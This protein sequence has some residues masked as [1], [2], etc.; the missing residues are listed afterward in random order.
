MRKCAGIFIFA[1][2]VRLVFITVWYETGNGDRISADS[3]GYLPI[4]QSIV[5]WK[6]F[7]FEGKPFTR[8][9]PLYCLF[10]GILSKLTPFPLGIYIAQALIGAFSCVLLYVMGRKMFD[11]ISGF[12]AACFFSVDYATLRFTVEVMPE[13]IFVLWLLLGFY[14]FISFTKSAGKTDLVLSSLF[15]GL[16]ALTKDGI[17][18]FVPVMAL[19]F[20][21]G[22]RPFKI[23]VLTA[24][25]F[26]MLFVLTI[27]PWALRNTLL[28]GHFSLVT[29]S[30]GH[31]FY[32][33]NNPTTVGN[34]TGGEWRY[35][36]DYNYP[37]DDPNL[38][39]LYTW[40]A[41]RYLSQSALE[42]IRGNPG[43]FFQLMKVKIVNM[44]RPYQS[45]SPKLAKWAMALTYIP[46][47]FLGLA[48]LIRNIGRWKE[49]LPVYGLICY[50]FLIH[51]VLF[52]QI[53]FRYPVMP[54]FM[55]FAASGITAIKKNPGCARVQSD[56]PGRT[57]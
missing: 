39:P 24:V 29:T 4:G 16:A 46:V 26:L 48:G 57:Q 14:Y 35:E 7:Q 56:F 51:I 2:L 40:E 20:L 36:Y 9:A 43:R 22:R 34:P 1:L 25:S 33:G 11:E 42:F 15:M 53:R 23:G 47:M 50:F 44:W 30:G 10:V 49:F 21:A 45:D 5:E 37:Q 13:N 32:L 52:G 54:F 31:V 18:Y 19:G 28:I 3:T 38:P 27:G 12:F 55:L 8:R 6:G 41:D 17:V